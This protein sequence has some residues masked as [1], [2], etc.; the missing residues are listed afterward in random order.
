MRELR[1]YALCCRDVRQSRLELSLRGVPRRFPGFAPGSS[2]SLGEEF[3]FLSE[4]LVAD[5]PY[6]QVRQP[7]ISIPGIFELDTSTVWIGSFGRDAV[8]IAIG[9]ANACVYFPLGAELLFRRPTVTFL[10]WNA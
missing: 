10:I 9:L 8:T 4:S 6:L 1:Y 5:V 2:C 3:L 7:W